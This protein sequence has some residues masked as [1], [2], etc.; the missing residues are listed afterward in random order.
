MTSDD[1]KRAGIGARL[2]TLSAA[3]LPVECTLEQIA[4]SGRATL[5]RFTDERGAVIWVDR[6]AGDIYETRQESFNAAML[7]ARADAALANQRINLLTAMEREA[8]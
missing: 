3:K 5:V 2:W 1:L 4:A 6:E 7:I 8:T